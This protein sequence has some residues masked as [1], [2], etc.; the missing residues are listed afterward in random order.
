MVKH[1]AATSELTAVNMQYHQLLLYIHIMSNRC[2]YYIKIYIK[3]ICIV[4]AGSEWIYSCTWVSFLIW[5]HRKI[6]IMCYDVKMLETEQR[7][8]I[9]YKVNPVTLQQAGCLLTGLLEPL[10]SFQDRHLPCY[11]ML[12]TEV[13]IVL[14]LHHT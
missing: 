13:M 1:S 11:L 8:Q 7:L 12:V 4:L 5:L 3:Q 14:P 2:T 6:F 10:V 9:S